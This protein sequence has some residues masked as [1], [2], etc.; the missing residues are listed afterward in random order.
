MERSGRVRRPY[1]PDIAAMRERVL[2]G[3]GVVDKAVRRAACNGDPVPD[4]VAAYV[5][6]VRRHAYKV[7]DDEV[8]AL[9][10]TH[11]TDEIYE[12]TVATALGAGLSR[13]DVVLAAMQEA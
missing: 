2:D 4:D 12:L 10:A 3:P 5:D 6:K 11:S 7:T 1:E 13:L 9:R 8:E